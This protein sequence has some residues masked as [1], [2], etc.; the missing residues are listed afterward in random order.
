MLVSLLLALSAMTIAEPNH[1]FAMNRTEI[2][3]YKERIQDIDDPELLF[4]LA[5]GILDQNSPIE[6]VTF[7]FSG[8][9]SPD[10]ALELF[11]AVVATGRLSHAQLNQLKTKLQNSK[12]TTLRDKLEK[13][14]ALDLIEFAQLSR[15]QQSWT[16]RQTKSN[17]QSKVSAVTDFFNDNQRV[18]AFLEANE[19][20][21]LNNMRAYAIESEN[22][23]QIVNDCVAVF[24]GKEPKDLYYSLAIQQIYENNSDS[25]TGR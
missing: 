7:R 4:A 12:Y 8:I 25:D 23:G 17:Q 19:Q 15:Q 20:P 10:E 16:C 2:Q 5:N 24:Q 18:L 9:Q 14:R 6:D 22:P 11:G 13:R 1:A 21:K 3:G